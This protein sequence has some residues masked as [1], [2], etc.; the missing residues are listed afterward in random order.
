M[1]IGIVTTWLERGAAYVSRQYR[2]VLREQHEVFIYARGGEQ[3]AK[4]DPNWDDETV[5]WGKRVYSKF[6]VS[7]II[8]L[9][10]F[11]QWIL[12]NQLDIV[13]FNEQNWWPP[14]DV[15]NQLGVI[16]GAYVDYYKENT[17]PLFEL[18][19][20]LICNT[21][22]HYEAF[23]WHPQ[24]HYIPWGTNVDVF[25]PKSYEPVRQDSIIFFHS[26]GMSPLYRKGTNF[27][28][29][30]YEALNRAEAHLIIHTQVD[31][32]E[33]M[34]RYAMLINKMINEGRLTIRKETT[35]APGLYHL[36]DV[37]VYPT[38][39]EGIGL[40]IVEAMS[41]GLPVIS[42]NFPPMNEF[43]GSKAGKLVAVK[44]IYSR[45]DGYY[46]PQCETDV[47]DLREQMA[48]YI[49]YRHNL[50]TFKK[51]ARL[52]A[53][54]YFDWKKR[55]SVVQKA[56][57][58]VQKMPN[59]ELPRDHEAYYQLAKHLDRHVEIAI[60]RRFFGSDRLFRI[61]DT[62]FRKLLFKKV[63]R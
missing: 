20:F 5:T 42:N 60:T 50:S 56:F 23:S 46:W 1:R 54:E 38:K 17:I 57:L 32:S 27:L 31:L 55:A 18:Y 58:Q 10:D 53:E 47:D 48:Y 29:D 41:C 28:L 4:H 35:G 52:H 36:G 33:K 51:Q 45:S 19:D 9:E 49:D 15:C 34:P 26:A 3:Y 7:N 44:K 40:T 62:T 2:D 16:S 14:V 37:Y 25:T 6:Y 24:C 11:R 22:R 59:K 13:F 63:K 30:A 39:L 8:D 61:I 12:K 21:K 43:I